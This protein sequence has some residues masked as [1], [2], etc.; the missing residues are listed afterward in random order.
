MLTVFVT[1]SCT[2]VIQLIF[3]ILVFLGLQAFCKCKTSGLP[4]NCDKDNK[5]CDKEAT[6]KC[7][8]HRCFLDPSLRP[9]CACNNSRI[10]P[11]C[12]SVGPE[13]PPLPPCDPVKCKGKCVDGVCVCP[14]NGIPPNCNSVAPIQCGNAVPFLN[15]SME[16]ECRCE[17]GLEPTS[18]KANCKC[19]KE[20]AFCR[21]G[22]ACVCLYG[23]THPKCSPRPVC[24][25]GG[26]GPLASC[27]KNKDGELMC[28]C[29]F[30]GI[31]PDCKKPNCPADTQCNEDQVAM[32]SGT[33]G[34]C[35]CMCNT[36]QTMTCPVNPCKEKVCE[37]GTCVLMDKD[38]ATCVCDDLG[39]EYPSCK[40]RCLK[41][42]CHAKARCEYDKEGNP[43]CVCNYEP[44]G[45]TPSDYP[46]CEGGCNG[47]NC[48]PDGQ[49]VTQE[50]GMP[51]CI[52]ANKMNKWPACQEPA[53]PTCPKCGD[54]ATCVIKGNTA[55]CVC[56]EGAGVFPD[57]ANPTICN[58]ENNKK[59]KDENKNSVCAVKNGLPVCVCI[60]GVR[61][62]CCEKDCGQYGTCDLQR[63]CICID[64][65]CGPDAECKVVSSGNKPPV[66]KCKDAKCTKEAPKCCTGGGDKDCDPKEQAKCEKKGQKCV[67]KDGK[68]V[69]ECAEGGKCDK[70]TTTLKSISQCQDDEDCKKTYKSKEKLQV[71]V[72]EK[73]Q[74][75]V[76]RYTL[77]YV[78]RKKKGLLPDFSFGTLSQ[79]IRLFT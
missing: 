55:T 72:D 38:K 30:N 27:V 32:E 5:V 50:T 74:C 60:S 65:A 63:K 76:P 9:I 52:C 36:L 61:P 33:E 25:D 71:C 20:V 42:S 6:K 1:V 15:A 24:P 48:E 73:C 57:C 51:M 47:V 31:Y 13:P 23:G 58:A 62:L 22:L 69:C 12:G 68:P 43:N 14:N 45:K 2:A 66:C 78:V 34:K 59:C 39:R 56:L 18:C 37:N 67:M 21:F 53:P 44:V 40:G 26:C 8:P 11:N 4:P 54:T 29:N 49:C 16:W 70:E 3:F 19:N 75:N 28:V 64:D 17:N 35:V 79:F 41:K 10:W 7:A 46:A 77:Q